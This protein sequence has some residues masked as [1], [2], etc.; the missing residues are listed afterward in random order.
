VPRQH[1]AQRG[2]QQTIVWLEAR[3]ANLPAKNL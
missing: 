3:L 1:L 2:K